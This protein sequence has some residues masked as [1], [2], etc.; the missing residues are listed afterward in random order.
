MKEL[1]KNNFLRYIIIIIIITL[2]ISWVSGG[3]SEGEA[4]I[5]G[6]ILGVVITP[7]QKGATYLSDGIGSFF[8]DIGEMKNALKENTEL[9][10]QIA[11]LEQN[12]LTYEEFKIENERLRNLLEFKQKLKQDS[13]DTIAA[14]IIAKEPGNY[15]T[16]FTIDKGTTSGVSLNSII[17]TQQGLVG[18]VIEAGTTFSK[19][20]AI[21]TPGSNVSAVL[22]KTGDRVIIEAD[23]E[24]QKDGLC[25]MSLIP[26]EA[27]IT[28][29][30]PVETSGSGGIFPE[31]IF[32]GRVKNVTQEQGNIYK[33]V[34]VEPKVDFT[35]LSEVLII[36][37]TEQGS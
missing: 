33:E 11:K 26:A 21:I 35:K 6:N 14:E 32:I 8:G 5:L 3:V 20:I 9:K 12:S 19:I 1:L 24:L 27:N 2:L 13:F 31:G 10:E 30:D 36:K 7:L 15:F 22:T 16:T 37:M 25:K 28:V 34:I 17:I 29:G 4:G 23:L 18:R